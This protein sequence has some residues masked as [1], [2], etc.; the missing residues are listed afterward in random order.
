MI[1]NPNPNSTLSA[2]PRPAVYDDRSED[3]RTVAHRSATTP[4]PR[5]VTLWR[6]PASF[7]I[8]VEP[9]RLAISPQRP[10]TELPETMSIFWRPILL[11]S[12]GFGRVN[13]A[14]RRTHLLSALYHRRTATRKKQADRDRG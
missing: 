5:S 3:L 8:S 12:V 6:L 11:I 13:I 9:H 14:H 2:L 1:V 7:R 10:P 4:S